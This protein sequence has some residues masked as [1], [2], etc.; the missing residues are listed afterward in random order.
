MKKRFSIFVLLILISC[1]I[2]KYSFNKL[3]EIG[4]FETN[5]TVKKI[6]HEGKQ[7]AFIETRHIG[8]KDYYDQ[9]K[10]KIDSLKNDNY[11]FFLE[12]VQNKSN[13]TIQLLKYRK[14]FG[15][16]YTN[17]SEEIIDTIN[18]KIYSIV[19]Y[20][21]EWGLISQPRYGKFGL[22]SLNSKIVD[23]D[24]AE[25][26]NLYEDKFQKIELDFCDYS[27]PLKDK[28]DCKRKIERKNWNEFSTDYIVA[29][30]DEKVAFT[31]KESKKTK[32]CIIYGQNHYEGI[33]SN[34]ENSSEMD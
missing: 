11:Y 30:R 15:N 13:D 18:N 14:I 23:V 5:V 25:L 26:V 2:K 6:A 20:D 33:K 21:K 12:G 8:K 31:T 24:V 17:N 32:I 34:L 3:K 27:T 19:P 4:V 7:I 1:N 10:I 28:Y 9:M 29:F 22:D 16:I